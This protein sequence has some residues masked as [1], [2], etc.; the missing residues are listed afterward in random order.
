MHAC[1]LSSDHSFGL[2]LN[3]RDLP[4]FQLASSVLRPHLNEE[5]FESVKHFLRTFE[6]VIESASMDI[7]NAWKKFYHFVCH[8]LMMD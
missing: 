1:T 7:E 8:T 3:R 5:V 4:K 6:S 2:T